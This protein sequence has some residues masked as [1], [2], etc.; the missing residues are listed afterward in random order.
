MPRLPARTARLIPRVLMLAGACLAVTAAF[1]VSRRTVRA[2]L[3]NEAQIIAQSRVQTLESI[4]AV[5]RA[6][7]GTLA[8]DGLARAALVSGDSGLAEEVSRKLAYLRAETGSTIIYLV[9]TK[10]LTISASNWQEP[11]SFVGGNYAF[12]EYF[13]KA[14]TEGVAL[15]YA[16]GRNSGR[17]GLYLS[18]DI[19]EGGRLL[20]VIVVKM[21]FEAMET[22]WARSLAPSHV[23]DPTGQVVLASDP[24]LRFRRPPAA[25]GRLQVQEPVSGAA[26]WQLTLYTSAAAS[27]RAGV[28]GGLVMAAILAMVF[29]LGRRRRRIFEARRAVKEATLQY[30]RDLEQ[31]VEDR[32]RLLKAEVE[33]RH[34]AEE[35]LAHMQGEL[36]Q[37]NKLA[38]LGQVTAGLAHEVNQPLA[39][40][41]L[42]AD[43]GMALLDDDPEETRTNL[44]QIA[45]MTERIDRITTQ[46]R[47]FARKATGEL[48]AVPV[49]EVIEASVLLTASRRRVRG[50][51]L[52]I[53]G[54]DP[55]LKV[56]AEAVRLEQVLV[57]LIQNAQEALHDTRDPVI[58]LEVT[59]DE[60]TVTFDLRDNGPGI[61]PWMVPQLFMP[62]AT[63]KSEGLGL[64]LV[65]AR[66][67]A[68]DLGG[69]LSLAP[70]IPGEGAHFIL[71][72]Q[73]A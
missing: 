8:D 38:T 72:L 28:A 43:N 50:A 44:R 51:T 22:G 67:I 49:P 12:R 65:I 16:L 13:R 29:A 3:L 61:E 58:T 56:R 14:L 39:T 52:V 45:G 36:V 42:L 9:D 55:D 47:G 26:G 15:E 71:R 11:D 24:S 4:L 1:E 31:A 57:N 32:T 54:D 59:A 60:T 64:G 5:Q 62:F 53:R 46:L 27:W 6:V 18:H 7:A 34:H 73:R 25:A 33:E 37:A 19:R 30:Q 68:R 35:R 48:K 17:P 66:D 23:T 2:A 20:G 41:R 69:E 70:P 63:S 10:G 21:E 40:I